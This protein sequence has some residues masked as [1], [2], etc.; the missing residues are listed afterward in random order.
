MLFFVLYLVCHY[1]MYI[2]VPK[3]DE[4]EQILDPKLTPFLVKFEQPSEKVEDALS[5]FFF[6][7]DKY[8]EI[9]GK[10][11]VFVSFTLQY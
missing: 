4:F 3:M 9:K 1:L 6:L 8:E 2:S 5:S 10:V 7:S 11:E